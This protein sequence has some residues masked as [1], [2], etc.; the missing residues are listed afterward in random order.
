MNALAINPETD[1]VSV[2]DKR[3]NYKK[4]LAQSMYMGTSTGDVHLL[5]KTGLIIPEGED[6]GS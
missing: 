6:E 2:A 4:W 1:T 3:S 5:V